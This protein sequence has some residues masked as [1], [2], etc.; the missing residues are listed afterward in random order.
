MNLVYNSQAAIYIALNLVLRHSTKH[1]EVDCHFVQ[2]KLLEKV[3]RT[4]HL[5]SLNQSAD[6]CT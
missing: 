5:S 2:E 4:S 1:F 6:L 3:M